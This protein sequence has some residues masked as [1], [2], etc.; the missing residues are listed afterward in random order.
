MNEHGTNGSQSLHPGPDDAGDPGSPAFPEAE[1]YGNRVLY[2]E[3]LNPAWWMWLLY[4]GFG[5]SVL[6][7]LS[8]ISLWLGALGLVLAIGITAT[9]AYTRAAQIVVTEEELQVGRA[10]IERRFVGEVEPF[11]EAGE[12]RRV[13][14]P[15]L[16]ARAFMSFS[17]S[18][19]PI[20]RIEITDPVDPT[21]Y[22][23]TST[24]RPQQL[25][26]VLTGASS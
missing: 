17:A 22:W 25:A 13:R 11:T 7:A 5:L 12:I 3:R 23:L 9:V 19:G 8:P 4:A 18:V 6:L 26:D 20:C 24:R 21:P 1:E 16:D 14:G 2:R 10:R 15:E